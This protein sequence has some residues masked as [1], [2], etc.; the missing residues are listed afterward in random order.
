MA[1]LIQLPDW[2]LYTKWLGTWESIHGFKGIAALMGFI[3][4]FQVLV[5]WFIRSSRE[6]T[7][8]QK[9]EARKKRQLGKQI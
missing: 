7:E 6:R 1:K 3:Y 8:K 5:G 9:I 2:G 4:T